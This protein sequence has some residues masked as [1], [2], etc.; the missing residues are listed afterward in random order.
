MDYKTKKLVLNIIKYGVLLF[1]ILVCLLPISWIWFSALKT[2]M[3]IFTNPFGMPSSLNFSNIIKAWT[4]GRFGKYFLNSVIIAVPTV[5][6]VIA[7]SSLAGFALGKLKFK[8]REWFFALF[9]LGLTLPFQALMIP[10]YYTLKDLNLLA[11]YLGVIFPMTAYGLPFGVFF[12]RAFF[13]ELPD[14]LLE[15]ARID[16]CSNIKLFFVILLPLAKPAVISLFIFQFIASWNNFLMPLLFLQK[17]ALRPLTLGL[18]FFSGAYTMD[19]GLVFAGITI[20]TFPLIVIY[21]IFQRQ[22]ITGLTSG[23]VKS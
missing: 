23:A 20:I 21:I 17:E 18:M 1:F 10:L 8:G 7:S 6:L 4:A 3:E 16:G 22:F 12:M 9:L 14:E 2:K 11:N 13:K 19:Y 15:A 5:L